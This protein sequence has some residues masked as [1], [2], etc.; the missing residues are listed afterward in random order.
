[1]PAPSI[2]TRRPNRTPDER[3]RQRIDEAAEACVEVLTDGWQ[4]TVASRAETYVTGTTWDKLFRRRR[5]ERCTGLARLASAILAG[6]ERLHDLVGSLAGWAVSLFSG[7]QIV[8]AFA[9][10]LASSLPLP[11]D[12]KLVATARGLQVTGVLLCLANGDDLTHCR[13]FIDLALSETKTRV[14]KILVSALDDWTGLSAFPPPQR[15]AARP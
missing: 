3:Q 15:P 4:E 1:M 8:R 5:H 6:K 13:C 2:R 12:A 14:R 9:R 10:E 11:P 7:D